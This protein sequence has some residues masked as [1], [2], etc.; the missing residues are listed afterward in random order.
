M[1][2]LDQG[3]KQLKAVY[4]N[5]FRTSERLKNEAGFYNKVLELLL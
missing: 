1:L 5:L 2:G 4:P 3:S